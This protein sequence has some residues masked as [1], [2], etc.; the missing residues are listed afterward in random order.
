MSSFYISHIN[1]LL[2]ILFIEYFVDIYTPV[3]NID[4]TVDGI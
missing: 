4:R 2:V 1:C 3:I